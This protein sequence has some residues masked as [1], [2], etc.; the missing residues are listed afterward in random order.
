MTAS[1]ASTA[2]A[3]AVYPPNAFDR[4]HV[5]RAL[6]ERVRYRYVSPAL[7]VVEGGFRI[8]SPCCSRRVD[9]DGGMV[10]IA[11]LLRSRPG[12][13]ELYRKDH[14]AA[15]WLLHGT[16]K[17]LSDLLEELKKDPQQKIWQ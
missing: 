12:E 13:W 2:P 5:E 15:Q 6:K 8:E 17:W 1:N 7:R 4:K 11:L 9:A 16:Y 14:P 3:I 10:D